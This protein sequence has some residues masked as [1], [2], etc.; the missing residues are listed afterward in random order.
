MCLSETDEYVKIAIV[1]NISREFVI[2]VLNQDIE[3]KFKRRISTQDLIHFDA[4]LYQFI[5]PKVGVGLTALNQ[6]WR[7]QHD[8]ETPSDDDEFNTDEFDE[9]EYEIATGVIDSLGESTG[10]DESSHEPTDSLLKLYRKH[11]SE[12]ICD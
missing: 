4:W 7:A 2:M 11:K 1:V 6:L 8:D 9:D 12:M 5:V 10:V 3:F